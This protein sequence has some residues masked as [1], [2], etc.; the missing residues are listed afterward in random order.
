M[1]KGKVVITSMNLEDNLEHRPS[2]RQ[3]RSSLAEYMNSPYF[4]PECVIS[5]E[6]IYALMK[7]GNTE[8]DEDIISQISFSN[9]IS[10]SPARY[11]SDDLAKTIWEGE[12]KEK[13]IPASIIFSLKKKERIG[14]ININ[15]L[16][17][18]KDLSYNVYLSLD[19]DNWGIPIAS[20]KLLNTDKLDIDLQYFH[21]AMY[22]RIDFASSKKLSIKEIKLITD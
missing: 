21:E 1:G 12:I 16:K 17:G 8:R 22:V 3:F 10:S 13:S 9:I 20:G 11:I 14:N 6:H 15:W 4:T 7:V 18:D 2:A 19:K 5:A